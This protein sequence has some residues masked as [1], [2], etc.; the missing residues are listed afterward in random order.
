MSVPLLG[1]M[2]IVSPHLKAVLDD[3]D[4]SI[5]AEYE[6]ICLYTVAKFC[7]PCTV[8]LKEVPVE[9]LIYNLYELFAGS[10]LH[11]S[12]R[13]PFTEDKINEAISGYINSMMIN[14]VYSTSLNKLFI[15]FD[16]AAH[17]KFYTNPDIRLDLVLFKALHELNLNYIH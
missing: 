13:L 6:P 3:F 9:S 11:C 14:V 10:F 1:G 17:I 12:S 5:W 15:V 4:L 16:L 7:T 2:V 8:N